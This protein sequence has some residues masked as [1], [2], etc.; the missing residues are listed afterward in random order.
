MFCIVIYWYIDKLIYLFQG[1]KF[2]RITPPSADDI[3]KACASDAE[4]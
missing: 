3:I 2:K 1:I 4:R